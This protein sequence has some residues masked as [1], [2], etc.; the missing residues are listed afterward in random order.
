MQQLLNTNR[1]SRGHRKH[2]H[3]RIASGTTMPAGSAAT[4]NSSA[5]HKRV[6]GL[7]PQPSRN[8]L[9]ATAGQPKSRQRH[10]GAGHCSSRGTGVHTPRLWPQG[11][12]PA[13]SGRQPWP[14]LMR[15]AYPAASAYLPLLHEQ[16]KARA[17]VAGPRGC[18][19]TRCC[20]ARH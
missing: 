15:P 13:A 17:P 3:R 18:R 19:F 9:S 4:E 5:P 16:A 20:R 14:G 11:H 6:R 12:M 7:T 2:N 10:P 1:A 8:V